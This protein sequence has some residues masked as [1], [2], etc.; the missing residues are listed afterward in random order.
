MTMNALVDVVRPTGSIGVVGVFVPE[1][2]QAAD[3]L[4]K[5][6]KLA[7]DFGKFFFKGQKIGTGQ[8]NV[9][10]YNRQLRD[11]IH[12]DRAKPSMLVS[13][14]LGLDAAPDAYKHFDNREPGWTKVVLNPTHG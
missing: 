11:L 14:N 7:F 3:D 2:P 6:G 10:A 5:E 12:Q 13:H 8:A 9:K 1:D 4:A